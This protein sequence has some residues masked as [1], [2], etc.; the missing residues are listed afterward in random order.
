MFDND[1]IEQF[2]SFLSYI[3]NIGYAEKDCENNV[4]VNGPTMSRRH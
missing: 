1:Y 3:T 4:N 2:K